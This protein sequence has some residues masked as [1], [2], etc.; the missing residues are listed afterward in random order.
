MAID[1]TQAK[2]MVPQTVDR[3]DTTRRAT[4]NLPV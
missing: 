2:L 4:G 1:F 3:N